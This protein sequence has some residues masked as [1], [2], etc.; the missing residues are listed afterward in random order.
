MSALTSL[1]VKA[2]F[3]LAKKQDPVEEYLVS[4]SNEGERWKR[5]CLDDVASMYYISDFGRI[6]NVKNKKILNPYLKNCKLVVT[7]S[8]LGQTNYKYIHRLV[9]EAFV[10]NPDKTKLICAYSL[11]GRA[12]GS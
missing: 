7:L 11:I 3:L 10:F 4:I 9:A 8:H 6:T 5:I 1:D 2:I 12:P